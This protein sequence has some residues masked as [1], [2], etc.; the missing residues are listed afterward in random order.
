MRHLFFC[1][2]FIIT[3]EAYALPFGCQNN[4][5]EI[6]FVSVKDNCP[7]GYRLLADH[8]EKRVND[9]YDLS[10]ETYNFLKKNF[11]LDALLVDQSSNLSSL[12]A[13][14]KSTGS[15]ESFEKINGSEFLNNKNLDTFGFRQ[16]DYRTGQFYLGSSDFDTIIASTIMIPI[17]MNLKNPFT[18]W[19]EGERSWGFQA[20][21]TNEEMD[22]LKKNSKFMSINSDIAFGFLEDLSKDV[23]LKT[24]LYYRDIPYDSLSYFLGNL[25][26]FE[27][28]KISLYLTEVI[29]FDQGE[30]LSYAALTS[31]YSNDF[32]Q[33]H[34]FSNKKRYAFILGAS[35]Y[36][37]SPIPQASNDALS[38]KILLSKFNFKIYESINGSIENMRETIQFGLDEINRLNKDLNST[39]I[40]FYFS[41]HGLSLDGENFLLPSDISIIE[42]KEELRA[43][44]LSLNRTVDRLSETSEGIKIFIIDSC[45]NE[46][47]SSE[48]NSTDLLRDNI[49]TKT[50][51]MKSVIEKIKIPN[52]QITFVPMRAQKNS[53]FAYATA[54]GE[55]AYFKKKMNNSFFTGSLIRQIEEN[56]GKTLKEIL[57]LTRDDVFKITDSMQTTWDS[58]SLT[59]S[60]FFPFKID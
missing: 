9:K 52:S 3:S 12:I 32:I 57:M 30:A 34:F 56:P 24:D 7:F 28:N 59:K 8:W 13:R 47:I 2:I 21:I 16:K 36:Q 25:K 14:L 41:G 49:K 60:Y 44:A 55:Y 17:L 22:N 58:S 27:G 35:D 23:G 19:M 31:T 11:H 33:K 45:R 4:R 29:A 42:S 40:I 51:K 54:P 39:E 37:D 5:G 43:N 38:M 50:T 6:I 26:N 18:E 15:L 53:I 10:A 1:L 20:G 48:F 46:I